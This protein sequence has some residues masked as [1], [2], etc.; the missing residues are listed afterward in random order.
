MLKMTVKAFA[1]KLF[2]VKYERL[3]QTLFADLIVFWGLYI[4]DLKIQIA[5]SVLYLTV[6]IF[7]AGVMWRA[8]TSGDIAAQTQNLFLLPFDSRALVFSYVTAFGA[9][10]LFTKTSALL[11]VLLAV[12][13][14]SP[15]EILGSIFCV[16][17][18][19]LMVTVIYAFRNHWFADSI[20]AAGMIGFLLFW[21]GKSCFLPVLM[22][23]GA[24]AALFLWR[25][26]GYA[27]YQQER[28]SVHVRKTRKRPSVWR[29]FFRYLKCHKNYWM[30]TAVLWG[31]ALVLP[32]FFRQTKSLFAAPIGFAILS[33]N[34]PV[35]I[36]LSCDPALEQSIRFLPGQKRAFCMPY[37]LFI[38]FCNIVADVIYLC[39][40]Q[41]QNG[42]VT[43]WMIA[44]AIFFALQS[45]VCS[46][47][48]EWFY[49]LRGWSIES[50][51]WHHP[52]KYIVPVCM[53]LLAAAAGSMPERMPVLLVFLA[54]EVA[55]LLFQ[56]Y[57]E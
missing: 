40:W 27:F 1:K 41:L 19:V 39:S 55:I 28:G 47:L 46:V 51:L 43:A 10:T 21:W 15:A 20:W 56:C 23:N 48:L 18:A 50:D 14:W 25:A 32:L 16:G 17:N 54:V 29:Y 57:S 36:L 12:S 30:N 53:L 35:C 26:D 11:A 52:R 38:F 3:A 44:A 9:Y 6:S 8:L 4:A 24:L 49:P 2:G 34:T 5:P 42:G 37:C 45:A 13:D 7:T 33:L 22:V 31:V